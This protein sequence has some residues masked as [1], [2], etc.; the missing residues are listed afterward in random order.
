MPRGSYNSTV[1]ITTLFFY[2]TWKLTKLKNRNALASGNRSGLMTTLLM[3]PTIIT[4]IRILTMENIVA[5][6]QS[7]H[8][9][10]TNPDRVA[11]SPVTIT[12]NSV[13]RAVMASA[14]ITTTVRRVVTASHVTTTRVSRVA[15]TV[16]PAAITSSALTIRSHV[17]RHRI[18]SVK[19]HRQPLYLQPLQP[20]V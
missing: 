7:A 20:K 2:L 1:G 15:T 12:A 17:R 18:L 5:R 16:V 3:Q 9:V 6:T 4:R 11:I 14:H 13:R 10:V 8:K 19:H